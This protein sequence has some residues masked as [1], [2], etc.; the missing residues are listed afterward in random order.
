[1]KRITLI[2]V[3]MTFILSYS[4]FC[5]SKKMNVSGYVKY[6]QSNFIIPNNT[7]KLSLLTDNLIHNRLNFKY[8]ASNRITASVELRNRVFYGEQIKL[9][10]FYGDVIGTDNGLIDLSFNLLNKNSLIINSTI[11]R[12]NIAYTKDKWKLSIGRQRINWGINLVWTPNDVF[13]AFNYLDF[14]YEERAGADAVRFEYYTGDFSSIDIAIAPSENGK[15]W[16][17]AA[18]Y[19]T[20]YKMYD[21]QFIGS[22]YKDNY[23]LGL[24]W[25]GNLKTASFKGEMS[26]F[27]PIN[28]N[29]IDSQTVFTGTI[30]IDYSLKNGWYFSTGL[31][32]V[33]SGSTLP[34]VSTT[35]ISA[36][37]S[38]I[39]VK[40]L[41]PT[42]YTIFAQ[43]SKAINP[44][45]SFSL[46]NM[47]SPG[48]NFL[49][50]F[51]TISYSIKENWDLD[52][53][54]QASFMDNGIDFKHAGS[55]F[56]ARLKRSF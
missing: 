45:I 14:D 36:F 23:M 26:I 29:S 31:L 18:K 41:M 25:A 27:K 5:Q 12:A 32:Y 56:F 2:I 54:A 55:T 19:A 4:A 47:Y 24:G 39:S 43:A 49:L 9:N 30:G 34:L 13:N 38:V 42:K 35:G 37:N 52:F 44:A 33:S 51:P 3:L 1:M 46:T 50:F 22:Y 21:L 7:G 15:D 20:N 6:M 17:A 10:P 11:D 28:S 8:Y 53:V 16:V 40:Q 48:S